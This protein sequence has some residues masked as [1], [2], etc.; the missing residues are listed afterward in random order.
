MKLKESDL[1]YETNESDMSI[2]DRRT[3]VNSLPIQKRSKIKVSS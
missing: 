1:V 2:T 3:W